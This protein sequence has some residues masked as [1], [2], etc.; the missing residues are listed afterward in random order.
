MSADDLKAVEASVVIPAHN[1][2]ETLPATLAAL[3]AQK[4]GAT[5]EVIV[6]DDGS[7]D[8]TA[9][10]AE[11]AGTRLVRNPRPVGPGAARNAGVAAARGALLA[12]TDADCEPTPG[13]LD[14]GVEA[15]GE[16]GL[17]QGRVAPQP[18]VPVGPFDR[19]LWVT[20]PVG[21]FE[22]ANLFVRR[23]LFEALG[24]F[25]EGLLTL[26]GSHFGEDVSFGWRVRRGGVETGF[27][28]AALVHHAV[29]TR[30]PA[31][32]LR[33]RKRAA[34]FC[35][36]AHLVP[37]LR[38]SLFYRRWFLSRRSAL[39]TAAAGGILASSASRKPALALA[40]VPYARLLVADA[41]A[42]GA[43]AA[44]IIALG[45]TLGLAALIRGTVRF[46]T[47]VL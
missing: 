40:A 4:T 31:E 6:V 42:N 18:G 5:F 36:L 22:S 1:A 12:F 29:F 45:D 39:F 15:L 7:T 11:Q 23:E 19:T 27:S 37:E 21:L 44:A 32:Y 10:I 43:K 14:A 13:W 3:A 35:A 8:D 24:G 2:A 38:R 16:A 30:G 47:L 25:D 20:A 46:R 28:E 9:R 26:A 17:V 33:E 34:Y 41:R